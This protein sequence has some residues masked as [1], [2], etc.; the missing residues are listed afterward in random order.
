MGKGQSHAK[1]WNRIIIWHHTQKL[2]LFSFTHVNKSKNNTG[3]YWRYHKYALFMYDMC[4]EMCLGFREI[5]ILARWPFILPSFISQDFYTPAPT[6]PFTTSSLKPYS[7]LWQVTCDHWTLGREPPLKC[8]QILLCLADS[9]SNSFRQFY[10]VRSL[11]CVLG[12]H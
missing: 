12:L 1:Q 5:K 9:F 10:W 6:P 4:S 7:P 3:W 8:C 2:T 11:C